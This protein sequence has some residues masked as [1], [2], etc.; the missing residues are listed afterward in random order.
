MNERL[1][2]LNPAAISPGL[3]VA[4]TSE[5]DSLRAVAGSAQVVA[6]TVGPHLEHDE[7]LVAAFAAAGTDYVDFT[8]EPEFIDRMYLAHHATAVESGARLVH[9]CGFDFTRTTSAPSSPSS[10]CPTGFR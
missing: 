1:A 6:T 9:A 2:H 5:P 8:G 4:D 3:L 10:N 7:P